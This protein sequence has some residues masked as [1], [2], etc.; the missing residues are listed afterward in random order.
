MFEKGQH[1][2]LQRCWLVYI[3]IFTRTA[4]KKHSAGSDYFIL[5]GNYIL[6]LHNISDQRDHRQSK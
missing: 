4:R 5:H 1:L 3:Q 2:C 6:I